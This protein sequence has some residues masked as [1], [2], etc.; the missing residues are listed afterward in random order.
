MEY[1][2]LYFISKGRNIMN[3]TEIQRGYKVQTEF[4][5]NINTLI[6]FEEEARAK[7]PETPNT[8]E[9]ETTNPPTPTTEETTQTTTNNDIPI[10]EEEMNNLKVFMHVQ[11][12][13]LDTINKLLK[14]NEAKFKEI[15]AKNKA[16]QK[17]KQ[18]ENSTKSTKEKITKAK[19]EAKKAQ[20]ETADLFSF[21][22]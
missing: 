20:D 3:L 19:T 18:K 7:T 16:E 14:K 9:P 11:T 2:F 8:N 4:L 17:A 22:F 12:Q 15:E 5:D 1:R 21:D 10:T 13:A 6:R